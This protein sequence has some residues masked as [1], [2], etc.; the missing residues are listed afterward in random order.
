MY[1]EF[2]V[3]IMQSLTITDTIL[4]LAKNCLKSNLKTAPRIED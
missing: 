2:A 3:T 1:M 4:T